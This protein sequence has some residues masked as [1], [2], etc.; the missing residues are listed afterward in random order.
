[1]LVIVPTYNEALSLPRLIAAFARVPVEFDTL[2]V[3]DHSPDGTADWVRRH[4]LFRGRLFLIERETKSG[5]GSAYR[6]GFQWALARPYE[7]VVMIDADLSHDPD[8]IPRLL[9]ALRNNFDLAVGSRYFG[10]IRVLNW[11]WYR[12]A[13]SR[14]AG[15]YTRVFAGLPIS[16]P[17]SGF[18]A[19]SRPAIE[20]IVSENIQTEGYGFQIAMLAAASWAGLRVTE[21]PIVFTERRDGESKLSGWI[22][23]EAIGLVAKLGLRRAFRRRPIIR[24]V[25]PTAQF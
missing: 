4:P 19:L 14:L 25:A 5:L 12:L 22:A 18:K 6:A 20:Q 17:T 15:A 13:L 7:V 10:A 11:P 3:D 8:D 21:V 2:I 16:D 23:L 9:H 1:M 24:V